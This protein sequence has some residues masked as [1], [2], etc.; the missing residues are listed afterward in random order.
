MTQSLNDYEYLWNGTEAG[1]VLV[2]CEVVD[3]DME[4]LIYNEQ[5]SQMLL[6]EDS[7]VQRHACERL[8]SCGARVLSELPKKE[9]DIANLNIED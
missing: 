4:Y 3:S 9:F 8:L 6:I 1:W 2:R 7:E 5:K